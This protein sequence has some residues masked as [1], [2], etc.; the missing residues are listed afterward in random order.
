MHIEDLRNRVAQRLMEMDHL[1]EAVLEE[2]KNKGGTL[3]AAKTLAREYAKDG[4]YSSALV[5]DTLADEL[6]SQAE[7][8]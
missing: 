8:Q 4:D 6:E 2:W 3:E 1:P 7:G 5:A